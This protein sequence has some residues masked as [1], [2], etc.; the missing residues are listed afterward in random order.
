MFGGQDDELVESLKKFW[1]SESTGILDNSKIER[2]VPDIARQT[3][4]S[5]NGQHYET[6]LPWKEDCVPTSN[7]YGMCVARLQSLH[8]KLKNE[9]NLL[10]DYDKIIREQEQAKIVERIPEEETSS[11]TS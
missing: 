7:N 4:I 3:D 2:Q 5:F 10:S 11:D 6:R 9:P 8:H 1:E